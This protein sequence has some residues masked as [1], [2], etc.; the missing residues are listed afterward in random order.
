M[1]WTCSNAALAEEKAADQTLTTIASRLNFQA[2][3]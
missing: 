1:R 2:A 3:A